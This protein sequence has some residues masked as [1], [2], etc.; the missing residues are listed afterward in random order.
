MGKPNSPCQISIFGVK[1]IR[2]WSGTDTLFFQVA[3]QQPRSWDD[4]LCAART[5]TKDTNGDGVIDQYGIIARGALTWESMFG[6][7]SNIFYSYG[8]LD[9]DEDMKPTINSKEG[10]QATQLWVELM[11]TCAAPNILDLYWP[12]VKDAFASGAAAMVIDCDWFAAATFEKSNVSDVAGKLAYAVT[13]PGPAGHRVQDSW[14]WS[15]AMNSASYHK[16]AAW[17]FIQWATSKPIML[18]T[19]LEYE[20]WNPP[21]KSVWEDPQVVAKTAKWSNY[22][23]VVE[24]NRKFG[25]IVHTINPRLFATHDVWWSNVRNVISGKLSVR[26]ALSMAEQMMRKIMEENH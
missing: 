23:Q 21:R 15:L 22:R 9:F 24:E 1:C 17:L 25:K 3:D 14:F 7:Y 8:G 4:I 12:Q 16:K 26:D 18:H 10:I 6:G 2:P 20:N 5:L 11:R 19:T 13:P